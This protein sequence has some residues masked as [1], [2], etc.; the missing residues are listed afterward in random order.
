MSGW[1]GGDF[2][3]WFIAAKAINDGTAKFSEE[4]RITLS[5]HVSL[6]TLTE[7]DLID[8]GLSVERAISP[9]GTAWF[10]SSIINKCTVTIENFDHSYDDVDFMDATVVA[11]VYCTYL[12]R[13][14]CSDGVQDNVEHYYGTLGENYTHKIPLGTFTVTKVTSQS[15][16]VKLECLDDMRKFNVGIPWTT[17][18]NGDTMR[19]IVQKICTY[20]GVT[21]R[22][23]NVGPTVPKIPSTSEYS[24]RELLESFA[25]Y[26]VGATDAWCYPFIDE[27][28]ELQSGNVVEAD[29]MPLRHLRKGLVTSYYSFTHSDTTPTRIYCQYINEDGTIKYKS[30]SA[31]ADSYMISSKLN[32]YTKQFPA[33]DMQLSADTGDGGVYPYTIGSITVP[34]NPFINA[35]EVIHVTEN[36]TGKEYD[37]IASRVLYTF[38]RHTVIDS[39]GQTIQENLES[40]YTSGERIIQDIQTTLPDMI[41]EQI[42]THTLDRL[43]STNSSYT[44]R[45]QSDGNAVLYNGSTAKWDSNEDT[46]WKARQDTDPQ[47]LYTSDSSG[48]SIAAGTSSW[49]NVRTFTVP[50]SG[51]YMVTLMQYINLNPSSGRF[52]LRIT[53]A[54]SNNHTSYLAWRASVGGGT[55]TLTFI[56]RFAANTNYY[57]K[58]VNTTNV[59]WSMNRDLSNSELMLQYLH[60][61]VT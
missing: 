2:R 7:A 51:W 8:G 28:G 44:F 46:A 35:G 29:F 23:W 15:G 17:F 48:T 47:R 57:V 13:D 1:S 4:V 53:D 10:G 19:Q 12:V 11:Y 50:T 22:A 26:S 36:R 60:R 61:N 49:T 39:Y 40:G 31:S 14:D 41:D 52:A 24:G 42:A 20:C 59:A 30:S 32:A 58:A 27:N 43:T 3:D 54:D 9:S 5:D 16:R 21:L 38:G 45:M 37:L 56:G 33:A 55:L 34:E 18:S 6:Y 25:S